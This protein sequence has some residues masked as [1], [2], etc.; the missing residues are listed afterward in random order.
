MPHEEE[1][2]A[3]DICRTKPVLKLPLDANPRNLPPATCQPPTYTHNRQ[4]IT[5]TTETAWRSGLCE[6]F[7]MQSPTTNTRVRSPTSAN[8]NPRLGIS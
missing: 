7:V 8:V 4:S 3:A 1:E 6:L 5:S 2:H